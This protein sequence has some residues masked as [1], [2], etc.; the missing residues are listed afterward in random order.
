VTNSDDNTVAVLG[1]RGGIK[2]TYTVGTFPTGILFDGTN[3]WVANY[4]DS[5]VSKIKAGR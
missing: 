2:K 3:I 5:T 1:N 4:F